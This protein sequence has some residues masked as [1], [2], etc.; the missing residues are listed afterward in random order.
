MQGMRVSFVLNS[1]YGS[2]SCSAITDSNGVASCQG[3]PPRIS[4]GQYTAK[5]AA[6]DVYLASAS[7]STVT[8]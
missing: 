5:F 7:S 3:A 6:T 2:S 1:L 4:G 8:F